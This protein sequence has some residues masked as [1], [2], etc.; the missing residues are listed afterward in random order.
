MDSERDRRSAR[1]L[2]E[3]LFVFAGK[4]VEFDDVEMHHFVTLMNDFV[5]LNL[6][7]CLDGLVTLNPSL[8]ARVCVFSPVPFPVFNH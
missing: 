6:C 3:S 8:H 7:L 2:E 4:R 1:S 5:T